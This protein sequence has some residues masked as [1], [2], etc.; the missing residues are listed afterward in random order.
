MSFGQVVVGPP[1]SG[2]T[3]Y[4]YGM[5]QFMTQ[6]GRCEQLEGNP[7]LILYLKK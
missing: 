2:K 1:G 7:K 5:Y 6:I 4:C 3:T